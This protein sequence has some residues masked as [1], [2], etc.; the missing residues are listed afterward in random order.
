MINLE[1]TI[2]HTNL[3]KN[4]QSLSNNWKNIYRAKDHEKI[5]IF[6]NMI[7]EDKSHIIDLYYFSQQFNGK[8]NNQSVWQF[9]K[10]DMISFLNSSD[11]FIYM[12]KNSKH[13]AQYSD[14]MNFIANHLLSDLKEN[15]EEKDALALFK[16]LRTKALNLNIVLLNEIGKERSLESHFFNHL[17]K[18]TSATKI[19]EV[20]HGLYNS[21]MDDILLEKIISI[22]KSKNNHKNY[23][24]YDKN[25]QDILI[26]KNISLD[27]KEKFFDAVWQNLSKDYNKLSI[28]EKLI[29]E[30]ILNEKNFKDKKFKLFEIALSQINFN[31]LNNPIKQLIQREFIEDIKTDKDGDWK[32]ANYKILLNELRQKLSSEEEIL[33][34]KNIV[35]NQINKSPDVDFFSDI[36]KGWSH[37][38]EKDVVSVL[39]DVYAKEKNHTKKDHILN[40]C[41]KDFLKNNHI[42]LDETGEYVEKTFKLAFTNLQQMDLYLQYQGLFSTIEKI[43]APHT[44][45]IGY[46]PIPYIAEVNN[47]IKNFIENIGVLAKNKEVFSIEEY[48]QG[49]V[50]KIYEKYKKNSTYFHMEHDKHEFIKNLIQIYN[51]MP[52]EV[53]DLKL[54]D[55]TF[56]KILKEDF[57]EFFYKQLKSGKSFQS[58]WSLNR[59]IKFKIPKRLEIDTSGITYIYFDELEKIKEIRTEK[60][61]IEKTIEGNQI[62]NDMLQNIK[63]NIVEHSQHIVFEKI[64]SELKFFEDVK[65]KFDKLSQFSNHEDRFFFEK[66]FYQN[67]QELSRQFAIDLQNH[68]L[69]KML[70]P[71]NQW[72]HQEQYEKTLNVMHKQV[73]EQAKEVVN[74]VNQISQNHNKVTQIYLENQLNPEKVDLIEEKSEELFL[75]NEIKELQIEGKNENN[76]FLDNNHSMSLKKKF[77]G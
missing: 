41:L 1:K 14:K 61:K 39:F 72:I 67:F 55:K 65:Y 43:V 70:H 49:P 36:K 54:N 35:Q 63:K 50:L 48:P 52:K 62:I 33:M 68:E 38:K 58:F 10:T 59:W 27:L 8:I 57:G 9:Y 7:R 6:Q 19:L 73:V 13:V 64:Q 40:I 23:N 25:N 32:K 3:Y 2:N 12:K 26:S 28:I 66:K 16:I 17:E 77:K 18:Y 51:M 21:Q 71:E 15:Y 22:L 44:V 74:K 37:L 31:F 5:S 11:F 30:N 46:T 42:H 76:I 34:L 47:I 20:F 60:L 53:Q 29:K 45:F 4:K 69:E 24:L 75:N 56:K